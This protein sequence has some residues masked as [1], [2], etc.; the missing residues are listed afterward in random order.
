MGVSRC[1]LYRGLENTGFTDLTDQELDQLI[2][3]YKESHP[4]DGMPL[5]FE[6]QV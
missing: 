5:A 4:H 3:D 2:A 1:T 6:L